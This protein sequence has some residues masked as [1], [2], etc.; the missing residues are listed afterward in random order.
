MTRGCV[1]GHS[2]VTESKEISVV[3]AIVRQD[4][5]TGMADL[6]TFNFAAL[7]RV[8]EILVMGNN[9]EVCATVVRIEHIPGG[10]VHGEPIAEASDVVL[11]IGKVVDRQVKRPITRSPI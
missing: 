6:G 7:P 9:H 5:G 2:L 8:G 1:I 3:L 10:I 11:W 4:T